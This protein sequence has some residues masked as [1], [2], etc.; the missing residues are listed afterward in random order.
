MQRPGWF[1]RA[2]ARTFAFVAFIL[3]RMSSFSSKVGSALVTP[4]VNKRLGLGNSRSNSLSARG[5]PST[6]PQ[7]LITR[8]HTISPCS[9][10]SCQPLTRKRACAAARHK[11]T[12]AGQ[13]HPGCTNLL[14]PDPNSRSASLTPF[15]PPTLARNP[16]SSSGTRERGA[17]GRALRAVLQYAF[18]CRRA[19]LSAE[20]HRLP[21]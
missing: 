6:A 4:H 20:P 17:S 9:Q 21:S 7:R 1:V 8:T 12:P 18:T 14:K 3:L 10:A 5:Q 15:P 11:R 19:P 16:T 2:R 13:H